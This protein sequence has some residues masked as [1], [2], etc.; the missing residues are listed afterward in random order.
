VTTTWW[1][2]GLALAV[3]GSLATQTWQ[4]LAVCGLSLALAAAYGPAN[5]WQSIR[6]Y[7]FLRGF[8]LLVRVL[9]RVLF[10]GNG[11][12]LSTEQSTTVF[13]NLPSLSFTVLT[14][15]VHLLGPV[16]QITLSTAITDGLRLCAIVLGVA[17]ANII[18]NPR[19]LLRST[20]SA[21]YEVATAAAV[22]ISLAPQLISSINR[23]RQ[24]RELRGGTPKGLSGLGGV[25]IPVLEDTIQRSLDLAAS[26]DSRGFGRRGRMPRSAVAT[27]RITS[28]LAILILGFATYIL[29]TSGASLWMALILF[30]LGVALFAITFRMASAYRVRSRL[31]LEKR[32]WRDVA[33]ICV[34]IG[35]VVWLALGQ[36]KL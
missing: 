29:L 1:L 30:G 3:C 11:T 20:P 18:A 19:K 7:L 12:A 36:V 5:K 31:I 33:V 28:I 27:T 34:A 6:L 16:T 9:F 14:Q 24:A 13:I 17:M 32:T 22:A 15:T 8:I 2:L 25:V 4:L 21:L 23:V 10:S 26:M 35:A